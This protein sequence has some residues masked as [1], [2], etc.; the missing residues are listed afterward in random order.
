VSFQADSR[1]EDFRRFMDQ[2]PDHQPAESDTVKWTPAA[3]SGGRGNPE[4][5]CECVGL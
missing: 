1:R 2:V 4:K 5:G 3:R